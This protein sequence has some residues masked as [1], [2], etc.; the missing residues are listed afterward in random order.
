MSGLVTAIR[1]E[2][3]LIRHRPALISLTVVLPL[4]LCVLLAFVFRSG[5]ATNLPVDV[6]SAQMGAGLAELAPLIRQLW[7]LAFA[8]AGITLLLR[9]GASGS[10][11]SAAR[12]EVRSREAGDAL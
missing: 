6:R 8:Y 12:P 4:A 3:R 10:R 11:L 2:F 7:L 1:R 9:L 5:V